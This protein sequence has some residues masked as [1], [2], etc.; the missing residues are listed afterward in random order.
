M[1]DDFYVNKLVKNPE[2]AQ[3]V[4]DILLENFEILKIYHRHL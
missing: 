1:S 2:D 3:K 4:L